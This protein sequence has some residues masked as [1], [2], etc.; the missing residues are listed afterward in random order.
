MR[1]L[2]CGG[3]NYD[4]PAFVLRTLDKLHA[5]Q[6]I[7]AIMHGGASGADE[8]AVDWAMTKSAIVRCVCYA[9]WAEHGKAAGPMRNAKMLDWKPDLVVAF[10]GNRGTA[11]MVRRAKAAGI[12]V[13]E[14][15]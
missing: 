8:F 5:E 10:P 14:I 13:R 4:D 11:D 15:S 1:L 3:R 2:V 12:P 7:T 9:N 6:P